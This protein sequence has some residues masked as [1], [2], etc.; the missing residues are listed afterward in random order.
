MLTS[1]QTRVLRHLCTRALS[2]VEEIARVCLPGGSREEAARVLWELEWLGYV[3]RYGPGAVQ[4]TRR[5]RSAS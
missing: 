5:G 3:V 2:T 1:E 4:I